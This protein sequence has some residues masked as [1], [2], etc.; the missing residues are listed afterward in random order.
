MNRITLKFL[1]RWALNTESS[2]VALSLWVV[3][4]VAGIRYV[5]KLLFFFLFWL[6]Y[7]DELIKPLLSCHT[8]LVSEWT[9]G[10]KASDAKR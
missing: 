9:Y 6:I 7:S 1:I 8:R 3:E 2:L 4:G 5:M 10:T